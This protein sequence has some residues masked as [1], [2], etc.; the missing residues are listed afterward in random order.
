MLF[1]DGIYQFVCMKIYDLLI[2]ND[3]VNYDSKKSS[4]NE[5]F[6]G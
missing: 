2:C 6:C 3:C 1:N 4:L 5:S